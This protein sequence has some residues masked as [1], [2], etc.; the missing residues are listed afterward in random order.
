MYSGVEAIVSFADDLT[1][2]VTSKHPCDGNS[3]SVRFWM[4]RKTETVE[5]RILTRWKSGVSNLAIKWLG[6][7]ID[8]KLSFRKHLQYAC[9]KVTIATAAFV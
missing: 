5:R 4:D 9:Q 7:I 6:V 3:E 8:P 1:I 2:F